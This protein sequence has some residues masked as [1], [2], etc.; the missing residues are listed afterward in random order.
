[1]KRAFTNWAKW[2]HRTDLPSIS[3][4]GVYTIAIS[5]TNIS[6][7]PFSWLYDIV[8]IGM[9]NAKGGLKSRLR[10]FDNCKHR[11]KSTARNG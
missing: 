8:Y 10:Q 11:S 6:E 5:K 3:Y 1:M 9:T 2:T 4:P 7:T